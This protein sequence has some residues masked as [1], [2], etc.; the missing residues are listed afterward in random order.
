MNNNMNNTTNN[1]DDALFI[2]SPSASNDDND[3][4][5]T[6]TL[7][8]DNLNNDSKL[9]AELAIIAHD[10]DDLIH[11][12]EKLHPEVKL[13]EDNDSYYIDAESTDKRYVQD[14]RNAL[15][16][17]DLRLCMIL[18]R[19]VK[20]QTNESLDILIE[21]AYKFWKSLS[22]LFV[23]TNDN[24]SDSD[25]QLKVDEYDEIKKIV[26]EAYTTL[27]GGQLR[28]KVHAYEYCKLSHIYIA[29]GSLLGNHIHL[30][31][32]LL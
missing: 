1:D 2:L 12:E 6:I 13:V 21:C 4:I 7:F 5:T 15:S 17:N 32:L 28:H 23:V 24:D 30:I 8:N 26:K 19:H 11:I 10:I 14:A 18:L 16:V 29:E 20:T 27:L 22:P 25:K 31:I 3:N 9:D